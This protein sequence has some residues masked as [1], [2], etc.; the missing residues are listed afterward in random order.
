VDGE[1]GVGDRWSSD[2]I[3]VYSGPVTVQYIPW[4]PWTGGNPPSPRASHSESTE[5]SAVELEGAGK[6]WGEQPGF[7]VYTEAAGV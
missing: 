3:G 6:E 4:T 5:R 1:G 7:Q 2:N